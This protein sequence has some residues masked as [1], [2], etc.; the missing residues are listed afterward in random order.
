[1]KHLLRAKVGIILRFAGRN[2]DVGDA[3]AR[4]IDQAQAELVA[5][6]IITGRNRPARFQRQRIHRVD[7]DLKRLISIEN[8]LLSGVAEPV[9]QSGRRWSRRQ[10]QQQPEPCLSIT[11]HCE[12]PVLPAI[13]FR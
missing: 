12:I 1:M 3:D 11:L 2:L 5:V 7:D 9:E 8:F 10:Q 6:Q 4:R 13:Q